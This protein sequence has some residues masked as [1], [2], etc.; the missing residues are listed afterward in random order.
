MFDNKGPRIRFRDRRLEKGEMYHHYCEDC[1]QE[2]HP[3]LAYSHR[4]SSL[5]MKKSH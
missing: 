4:C 1:G 2:L 5:A 3:D